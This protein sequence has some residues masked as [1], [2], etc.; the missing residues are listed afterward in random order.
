MTPTNT[1][2]KTTINGQNA[3]LVLTETLILQS[4]DCNFYI[5]FP[6]DVLH[7]WVIQVIFNSEKLGNEAGKA[8]MSFENN[9]VILTFYSWQGDSV[10]QDPFYAFSKD[11]KTEIYIFVSTTAFNQYQKSPR[12]VTVS[13]WQ[14]VN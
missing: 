4:G 12:V 2:V 3:K 1:V 11:K 7:G 9:K 5:E 8:K 14:K 13:V 10:A 6:Q